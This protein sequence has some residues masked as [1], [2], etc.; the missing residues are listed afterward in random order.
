[1]VGDIVQALRSCSRVAIT[2]HIRPD[3]DAI[4]SQLALGLFLRKLG[5]QVCMVNTHAVPR[6]LEWMEGAESIDVFEGL[7]A[8]RQLLDTAQ[9]IVVVDVNAGH[10]LGRDL[11]GPVKDSPAIKVLIDHHRNP[12]SWFDYSFVR[13]DAA[14]AG[15]LVYEL[16][17]AWNA[18]LLTGA[19]ATALYVAILTD[20]GSFRYSTVTPSVHR[21]V[22]DLLERGSQ[23]PAAVYAAIYEGRGQEWPRLL[24]CAMN[25]LTLR[26][27]G[28]LAYIVIARRMLREL[29][30]EYQD[31]EG[32]VDFAMSV[33]GVEVA[34]VFSETRLGTKVSFRSKGEHAV[35]QWARSLG[36]GGHRNAAGAFV[37]DPLEQV[38]SRVIASAP[39]HIDLSGAQNEEELTS[40]DE[41]YLT[42]LTGT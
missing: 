16:I 25:T 22:A 1:M 3:G 7:L 19:I 42:M 41:A 20:T 23:K 37:H 31:T 38:I 33:D 24:G 26:Y 11:V 30:A 36:G 5:K 27:N 10:R 32:F 34:L 12:E 14:A 21:V 9:A 6:S 29:S 13:E 4:G 39:R 8:Q 2:T 40:D 35:D 17:R 18:E 28:K 15:M